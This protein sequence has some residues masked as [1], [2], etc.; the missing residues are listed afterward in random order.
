M[1]TPCNENRES[2]PYQYSGC[3]EDT[4]HRFYPKSS[5]TTAAERTFREL[6]ENKEQLCRD[7]HDDLHA[8]QEPP[9]K[10]SHAEMLSQIALSELHISKGTRK[11][12][13]M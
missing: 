13:G 5:Y 9:D 7:L 2:C 3:F 6:P 1:R 8:T 11:A 4:H 12:I 10:P